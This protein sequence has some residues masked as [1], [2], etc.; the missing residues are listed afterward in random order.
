MLL[1]SPEG[2]RAWGMLA[3]CVHSMR[4][5]LQFALEALSAVSHGDSLLALSLHVDKGLLTN[6]TVAS[7]RLNCG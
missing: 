3:V 4:N 6:I 5:G 1:C 7:Q 2:I